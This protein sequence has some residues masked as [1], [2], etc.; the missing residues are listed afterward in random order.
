MNRLL[1]RTQ[2]TAPPQAK[3]VQ[4]TSSARIL[5]LE[6]R[7]ILDY[8]LVLLE[9]PPPEQ[10]AFGGAEVGSPGSNG[11]DPQVNTAGLMSKAGGGG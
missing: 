8:A 3:K 6:L 1:A 7:D 9:P 5:V 11:E 10:E 2:P 4:L